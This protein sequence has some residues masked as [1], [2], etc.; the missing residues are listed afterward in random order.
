ASQ[1]YWPCCQSPRSPHECRR[2]ES[3][4]AR[5]WLVQGWVP[6]HAA[7][8]PARAAGHQDDEPKENPAA[9]ARVQHRKPPHPPGGTAQLVPQAL[10]SELPASAG[11]TAPPQAHDRGLPQDAQDCRHHRPE[12]PVPLRRAPQPD[13]GP[14]AP[15]LRAPVLLPTQLLGTLRAP[16]HAATARAS[17]PPALR[18]RG[19]RAPH[20]ARHRLRHHPARAGRHVRVALQLLQPV[21]PGLPARAQRV[22]RGLPAR[23]RGLLPRGRALRH[24]RAQHAGLR[25]GRRQRAQP[26]RRRRLPGGPHPPGGRGLLARHDRRVLRRVAGAAAAAAGLGPGRRALRQ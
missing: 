2:R 11:L 25:P 23:A 1:E 22:A 24:V 9:R 17:Q 4:I 19:A 5:P 6:H 20:A 26:A 3:W 16:S 15:E 21:L 7:H 10:S 8:P 12:H 18:P 13:G 14:A